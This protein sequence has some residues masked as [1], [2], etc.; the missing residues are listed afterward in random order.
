MVD[1]LAATKLSQNVDTGLQ[2]V[3]WEGS[4][5]YRLFSSLFLLHK[6]QGLVTATK[7]AQHP[8]VL[9]LLRAEDRTPKTYPIGRLDRDDD[10]TPPT[11]RQWTSRFPTPSSPIP[12]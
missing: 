11:H 6:P 5:P 8:T 1:G 3:R 4:D 10:R 12:Y 2:E 9:D 7:D